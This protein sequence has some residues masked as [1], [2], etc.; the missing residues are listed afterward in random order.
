MPQDTTLNPLMKPSTKVLE[1]NS[2][3]AD[4]LYSTPGV[5]TEAYETV[6]VG[7]AVTM[8]ATT[9][10][11]VFVGVGADNATFSVQLLA[12]VPV[13]NAGGA[14]DQAYILQGIGLAECTLSTAAAST[15]TTAFPTG[16][17]IVDT[18]VWTPCTTATT[19]VGNYTDLCTALGSTTGT[20]SNGSNTPATLILPLIGEC[21]EIYFD[22][23]MGTATSANAF[24]QPNII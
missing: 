4:F 13:A 19:L 1:T 24:F 3:E 12:K 15:A 8:N 20:V 5:Y 14:L 6:P 21:S 11:I 17:K 9:G 22:F 23:N 18:I 10:A 16:T 2:N 7:K